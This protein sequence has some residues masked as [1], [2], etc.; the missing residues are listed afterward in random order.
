MA[1]KGGKSLLS[2]HKEG[3]EWEGRNDRPEGTWESV[4]SIFVEV[5]GQYF[6]AAIL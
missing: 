4:T 5:L 1:A 6:C 2:V 3:A